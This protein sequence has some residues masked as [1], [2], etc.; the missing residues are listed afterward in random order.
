MSSPDLDQC[1]PK[2]PGVG[3][4][5]VPVGHHP[6]D[7]H[8]EL[9][10]AAGG[11]EHEAGRGLPK[12]V[13][14]H[15]DEGHPGMVVHSDV[16][17]VVALPSTLS[18]GGLGPPTAKPVP[19]TRGDASQLLHVDMHQ[20]PGT[21]PLVADGDP[22][23]PRMPQHRPQSVGTVAR[24]PASPQD[25]VYVPRRQGVGSAVRRG[26]AILEAKQPF[27][28]VA[29]DPL[30]H[31]CPRHPSRCSGGRLSP[32]LEENPI[33]QQP[34]AERGE[35]R[36]TMSHESLLSVRSR[37]PQTVKEALL[38]STTFVGT[39][40]SPAGRRSALRPPAGGSRTPISI[41]RPIARRVPARPRTSS[42]CT[43]C[44][45]STCTRGRTTGC[46]AGRAPP[47]TPTRRPGSSWPPG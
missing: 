43:A 47:G 22:G 42:G 20:L 4:G 40:P 2:G 8:P 6:L 26:G 3:V 41:G 10:E 27:L 34:S 29:L 12:L 31:S 11:I 13:R 18:R 45:R 28:P 25:A 39:T 32:P 15:L 46:G 21:F 17:V 14:M 16:E 35:S 24:A 23:G 44:S 1:L 9:G 37:Q 33:Y 19:T 38:M 7:L 36:P 30:G 5:Q